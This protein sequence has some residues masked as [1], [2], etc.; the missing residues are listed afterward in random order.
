MDD[1]LLKVKIV[2]DKVKDM[3]DEI[4]ILFEGLDG[5]ISKL[6]EI[7]NDFIKSAKMIKTPD[8]KAFIFSLDSFYFQNSLLNKEYQHLKDYYLIIINRMYGEYY[9]LYKL[10][11]EYVEKS[12][13]DSQLND[14]LKKK[15][16]PK[17]DDLNEEKQYDFHLIVNLN[18]DIIGVVNYLINILRDKELAL[19][20]Y[21]TNRNYGLN[22]DNFVSTY[23]YEVIVLQEQINLYEKYL[24][25]FYHVHEKLLKRL[26]TKI[27]VL[28]AQLN[29]DIKF[30]GGLIGKRKDNNDLMN[31]MNIKGLNKKAA[32]ELRKSITGVNSPTTSEDENNSIDYI[33]NETC[34]FDDSSNNI[35]CNSVVFN[36]INDN[37]EKQSYAVNKIFAQQNDEEDKE[38]KN[39]LKHSL[40]NNE[41]DNN[42]V[43]HDN[44]NENEN[45]NTQINHENEN[46][47]T[48]INHE[49][50]NDNTQ[51]NHENEN[52]N[53]HESDVEEDEYTIVK[54]SLNECISVLDENEN[55]NTLTANQRKNL[56]KRLKK[57][58]RQN[59]K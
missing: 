13:I 22:V 50:E 56:K 46:D 36:V 8:V 14:S 39:I 24:D 18:E 44:E 48:Q 57:K 26:I 27:S 43:N 25:F 6:G 10:I 32:R 9:K 1:K 5:R 33:P 30:E 28:E 19:K 45:D 40:D 31:D 16:Y 38:I 23:N 29:A 59:N 34:N 2:F 3:R 4:N 15:I 35:I 11:T 47:N 42:L 58:D 54:E 55:N 20:A 51:I 49:N 17:Y 53:N 37:L 7:Y 41:N 12:H 52:E 21:T